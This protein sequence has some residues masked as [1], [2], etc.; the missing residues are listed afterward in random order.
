MEIGKE[1]S[2]RYPG[3]HHWEN[4]DP[5]LI[6]CEIYALP[7]SLLNKKQDQQAEKS[8]KDIGQNNQTNKANF[9]FANQFKSI[10]TNQELKQLE[11]SPAELTKSAEC[12]IV[13]IFFNTDK[14]LLVYDSYPR[15][16]IYSKLISVRIP[17]HFF[18]TKVRSEFKVP[19]IRELF[20][21]AFCFKA[22]F[23]FSHHA[24]S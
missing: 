17:H 6:V 8:F 5:R 15:G 14:G 7:N 2:G 24:Y 20:R 9:S 3:V 19:K 21:K 10:N 23:I 16:E 4:Y 11:G 1:I 12:L 13:S 22:K 18:V